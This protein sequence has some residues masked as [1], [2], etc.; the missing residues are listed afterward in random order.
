MRWNLS[1]LDAESV[2]IGVHIS[3]VEMH[4]CAVLGAGNVSCLERCPKFRGVLIEG[5][6]CIQLRVSEC[7]VLCNAVPGCKVRKMQKSLTASPTTTK[8][9]ET[10]S[11]YSKFSFLNAV[12]CNAYH[13]TSPPTTKLTETK[14]HS[15]E[16]LPES[17]TENI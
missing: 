16:P 14:Q 3:E 1:T 6:H 13:I 11:L 4:A 5:F 9:T 10:S 15:A 7:N 12:L 2:L 8:L 17:G